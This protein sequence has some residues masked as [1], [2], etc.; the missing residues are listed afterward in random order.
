MSMLTYEQVLAAPL[1]DLKEAADQWSKA[2]RAIGEQQGNYRDQVIVPTR[3][4]WSGAD[5]DAAQDF[6]GKVSKELYDAMT[7]ADAIHGVLVDAHTAISAARTELLRL[8]EQEAPRLNLVVGAGGKVMA[9]QCVAE[10]DPDQE[11]RDKKNIE[12]ME[13]AIVNA[14]AAAHEADRAAAWALGR[15]TGGSD[16]EF[17]PGGYDTL[18][19]AEAG[20]GEA[21]F[22]DASDYIFGEM[23][24]NIDSSQVAAIRENMEQSESPWAIINPIPGSMAGPRAVGLAIWYE[25]VKSGGP[26]DHKPI[27]E[28]RYDL[29]SR[30]DFY[31]KVPDRD[32]EVSYD[33]YSNIHYGY[34][35]R[36]AGISRLELVEAANAGTGGTGTNDPG[37]DM[38]MKIGMDLY[39]KYGPN[40][41]KEQ[42]DAAVLQ[43]IDEM[44]AKRRAGDASIT[45]VRPAR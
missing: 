5:A 13:R 19:K 3:A 23:K 2:A 8:A 6:M 32:V 16:R 41:T 36:A 37:D 35:G 34:V 17:N 45:Q 28:K 14:R 12:E 44:E 40:M 21:H 22:T 4:H 29:Q 27:L 18:D 26:W 25:Q 20:L 15:N 30:N 38:S 10:P 7:E 24:T 39:E 11:A 9:A 43:L 31:F 33:I 1:A 42:M